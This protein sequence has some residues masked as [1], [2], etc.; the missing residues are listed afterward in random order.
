MKHIALVSLLALANANALADSSYTC[1]GHGVTNMVEFS[2]YDSYIKIN[3]IEFKPSGSGKDVGNGQTQV[4]LV[5][6]YAALDGNHQIIEIYKKDFKHPLILANT[7]TI[8]PVNGTFM[9]DDLINVSTDCPANHV[10]P[11]VHHKPKKLP[12][13]NLDDL[14]DGGYVKKNQAQEVTDPELI[15]EL[16]EKDASQW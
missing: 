10:K 4:D 15:K 12:T 6:V 14:V 13:V 9:R 16:N 3:G 8:T 11:V 5:S 1:S 7:D 2:P